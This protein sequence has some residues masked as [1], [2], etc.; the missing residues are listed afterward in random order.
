MPRQAGNQRW[1]RWFECARCGFD[2]PKSAL[3]RQDGL[4]V[5]RQHC[6]LEQGHGYYVSKKTLPEG[7]GYQ[8]EPQGDEA[9]I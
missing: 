2:Y 1:E 6:L 7:E 3:T 4:L 5:C 9:L 8:D